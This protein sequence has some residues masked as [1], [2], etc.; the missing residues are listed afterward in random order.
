M[1]EFVEGT[2]EQ[3]ADLKRSLQDE[4]CHVYRKCRLPSCCNKEMCSIA[5]EKAEGVYTLL[6]DNGITCSKATGDIIITQFSQWLSAGEVR[7]LD[8]NDVKEFL[9]SLTVLY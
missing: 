1:R 8:F 3:F 6:I 9:R 5:F 7:F 4:M 2:D